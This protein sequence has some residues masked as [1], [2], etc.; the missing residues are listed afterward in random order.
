MLG[1]NLSNHESFPNDRSDEV[2]Q[3]AVWKDSPS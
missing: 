2:G 3:I 1:M